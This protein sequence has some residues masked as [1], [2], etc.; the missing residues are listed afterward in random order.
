MKVSPRTLPSKEKKYLI[1]AMQYNMA[2]ASSES[3]T[4]FNWFSVPQTE[5]SIDWFFLQRNE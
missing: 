3:E 4:L 5:A 2:S 1:M